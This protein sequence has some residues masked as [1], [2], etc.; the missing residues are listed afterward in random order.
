MRIV[1]VYTGIG[2]IGWNSYNK[3]GR[4]LDDYYAIPQG[5]AYLKAI[6]EQHGKH[7]ADILDFR[8]M[9]GLDEFRQRIAEGKYDIAGFSCLT[10][11]RDYAVMGAEI[12]KQL[13]LITLA[14]GVHASACPEDFAGTGRFDCVV[15]GEAERTIFEVL[16]LIEQKT[17]LPPIYRT[18]NYVKN[19][20]EL[21]FPGTAYLPTYQ[22][23]FEANDGLAGITASRGCPGRCKY[24]WP[25]QFVMYGTKG[26]RLRSPENV[27]DEMHYLKQNFPI[28]TVTF[29][30]DTFTW[31]KK[32]LRG[33]LAAHRSV[34]QNGGELP[35]I[36]VNARANTFDEEVADVLKEVGCIGVWFGF[37][38]GSPKILKLLNKGCTVEQ[39][40]AA[41]RTCREAGFHVNA[42]IL[43]GVP[44]E[45]NEDYVL[46]YRFLEKIVPNNVRYNI[47]SP[48]PGSQ[49]YEELQ[50]EGLIEASC[51]E[52]FDVAKAHVTGQGIIKSVDYRLVMKWIKPFRSFME[53]SQLRHDNRPIMAQAVI[54]AGKLALLPIPARWTSMVYGGLGKPYQWLKSLL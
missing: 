34:R 43:V 42:N 19:L 10:P 13:G 9:S 21:P 17:P 3:H 18:V 4:G 54:I 11:S 50:R 44:G 33:F 37:E 1:F 22:R 27:I 30:D 46:T 40:V 16:D 32:W 28:N 20:D 38:S 15:V 7:E 29:Y 14:G 24:C 23:A 35:A 12:A 25:N 45:T 51:F 41:A 31:N 2:M 49:Y 5:L 53:A 8:M 26:I 6:L 47:L 48:Y 39:N 36:S 52:D